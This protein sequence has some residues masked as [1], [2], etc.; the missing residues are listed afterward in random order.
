[1]KINIKKLYTTS[2]EW[3]YKKIEE[4]KKDGWFVYGSRGKVIKKML[5]IVTVLFK[6]IELP[7]QPED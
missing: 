3:N 1:M 5:Y 7:T 4:M 6:N 2:I